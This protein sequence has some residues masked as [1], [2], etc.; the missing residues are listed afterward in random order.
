MSQG[1]GDN[2][3]TQQ[4]TEMTAVVAESPHHERDQRWYWNTGHGSMVTAVFHPLCRNLRDV[5]SR[6]L[7]GCLNYP[8]QVASLGRNGIQTREL[9][10][11]HTV[12]RADDLAKGHGNG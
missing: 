8:E 1:K 7:M 3:Q 5:D 2:Q 6:E 12:P 4:G 9:Y 10:S 11:R